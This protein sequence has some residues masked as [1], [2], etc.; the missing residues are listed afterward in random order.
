MAISKIILN[1]VT[2]MDVTDDTVTADKLLY[3]EQATGADGQKVIGTVTVT[4]ISETFIAS[5]F[6]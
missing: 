4:A 1:G 3:G 6:S 2:Q 5:L